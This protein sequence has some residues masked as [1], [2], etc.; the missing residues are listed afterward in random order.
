MMPITVAPD[1][2][3]E[4]EACWMGLKCVRSGQHMIIT[5]STIAASVTTSPTMPNG[6][7]SI[8]MRS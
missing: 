7:E 6:G 1:S 5:E 2:P 4:R 3:S 8:T